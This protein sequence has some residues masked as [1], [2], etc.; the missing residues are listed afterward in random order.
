MERFDVKLD[1]QVIGE[2]TVHREGLYYRFSCTCKLPQPGL[3]RLT[4]Q[5]DDREIALGIL[6]PESGMFALQTKIAGKKF[7]TPPT[8]FL[9]VPCKETRRAR[10]IPLCADA[11]FDHISELEYARLSVQDDQIG[12]VLPQPSA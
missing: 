4:T 6:V 9:V 10:F 3:Y 12:I 7:L 5:C 1:R 8:K 11:Q 2:V